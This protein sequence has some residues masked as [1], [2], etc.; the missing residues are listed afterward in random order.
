MPA[1]GS[2][3]FDAARLRVFREVVRR[4]S[5]SAAAEALSFT[6]PAVSRQIAALEREAGAQL[7]ERTP[8]GIRLTEAGRVL[9]V[10]AE[11]ILDRMAIARAQVESVASLAGGRLRIGSFQTANATIVPRAIAAFARE[12]PRVELSLLEATTPH[13]MARLRAGEIDVAVVTALPELDGADVEVVD[14]VDDEIFVALPARHPLAHKPRLRLRD[15]RDETWIEARG[16]GVQPPLLTAALASGFEP[17]IRFGAEQWLS[18]QGLVAAGVGVTL[19]PGLAIATV[20]EDIV[21]RSL[22]PDAPRRRV[23]AALPVGYRA[24]AVEP[25]LEL[26]RAEADEH[27]GDCVDRTLLD[28]VK[29][30]VPEPA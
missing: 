12:H 20:R 29:R 11:A 8:R 2:P 15:L 21:L 27:C 16:D 9:L 17:R 10:H 18:K 25:F 1:D 28:P 23:V 19:I 30:R 22:G 14:L 24:P 3:V 4:G 6:Q 13:A 7:L 26:L 5:L